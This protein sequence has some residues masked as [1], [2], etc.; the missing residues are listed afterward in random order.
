MNMIN[1]VTN[2]FMILA[3]QHIRNEYGPL[4]LSIIPIYSEQFS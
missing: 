4:K 1:R 3:S 2:M